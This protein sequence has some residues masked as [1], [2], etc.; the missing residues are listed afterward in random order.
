MHVKNFSLGKTTNER[1]AKKAG[2]SSFSEADS[3]TEDE[4]GR[5]ESLLDYNS[6]RQ[7]IV[8][9]EDAGA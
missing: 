4:N 3:E 8:D 7:S 5:T 6:S 9:D 2:T 1:F